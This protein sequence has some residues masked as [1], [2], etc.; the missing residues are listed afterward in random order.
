MVHGAKARSVGVTRALFGIAIGLWGGCGGSTPA[1]AETPKQPA[2]VAGAGETTVETE[3]VEI[4]PEP[5]PTAEIAEVGS[6]GD[7]LAT[8]TAVSKAGRKFVNFP[9]WFKDNEAAQSVGELLEDGSLKPFPDAAW[10]TWKDG[11]KPAKKLVCVQSVVVDAQDKLWILDAGAPYWGK[12]QKGAPKLVAVDLTTNKVAKTISFDDK[13]APEGAYLN[14]VRIDPNG[15]LAYISDSNLGRIVIVDLKKGK[16]RVVLEG[17]PSTKFE[18]GV[19][20]KVEGVA[21]KLPDGSTFKI[22]V[23]GIAI[24]GD[25]LY[26]HAV[27]GKTMYRIKLDLLRDPKQTPEALAAG[28]EK[29]ADTGI[30]DGIEGDASGNVY[31]TQLEDNSIKVLRPDGKQEVVL[32]DPR[33][34]WADSIGLGPDGLY[35]TVSQVHLLPL[36]NGGKSARVNPYRVFRIKPL[37]FSTK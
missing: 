16:S 25:Y 28:V 1:P 26:Y 19:L 13:A 32:K 10:N 31:L 24:A 2:Y 6:F 3:K 21:L 14:D 29:V 11:D 12:V 7:K 20:P 22:N 23:D 17:H 8:T 37:D 36:F 9:R 35:V 15:T 34:Q 27:T 30:H 18:E 4:A 33:L 5:A